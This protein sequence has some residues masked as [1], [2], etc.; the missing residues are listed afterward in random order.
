MPCPE[1]VSLTQ[2]NVGPTWPLH[3]CCIIISEE[4][5]MKIWIKIDKKGLIRYNFRH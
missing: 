1:V 4:N 3:A 5:K 2:G